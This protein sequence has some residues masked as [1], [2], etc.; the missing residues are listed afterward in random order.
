MINEI[1]RIHVE[2]LKEMHAQKLLERLK[3]DVEGEQLKKL[4]SE[5]VIRH[6]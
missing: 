6:L 1:E 5:Y 3:V 2:F 4:K